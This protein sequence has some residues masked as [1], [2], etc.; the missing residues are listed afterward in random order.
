MTLATLI[1]I[2]DSNGILFH[3]CMYV[4]MYLYLVARNLIY[5]Y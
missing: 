4:Y 1:E 5:I 3:S 2:A